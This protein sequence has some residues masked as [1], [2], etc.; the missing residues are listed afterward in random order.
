MD[1]ITAMAEKKGPP[2]LEKVQELEERLAEADA[3]L[4]KMEEELDNARREADYANERL[5]RKRQWLRLGARAHIKIQEE[6]L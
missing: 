4:R 1:H 3:N 5:V 6:G 2:N